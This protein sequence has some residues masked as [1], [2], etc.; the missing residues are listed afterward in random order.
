M[1]VE[2]MRTSMNRFRC[3]AFVTVMVLA[4]TSSAQSLSSAYFLSG[5]YTRQDLNPAFSPERA[6]FSLPV[7]GG[8]GMSVSSNVGASAFIYNSTSYP[9]KLT[10][11]MSGD[12][13]KAT[14]LNALPDVSKLRSSVAIDVASAGFRAFGGYG[15]VGLS[16]KSY[17]DVSVPK[18]LFAMMKSGLS[19]GHYMAG[20]A[21][22]KSL[23]YADLGLGYSRNVLDNLKLGAKVHFLLGMAGGDVSINR[24]DAN[25][26]SSEWRLMMDAKAHIGMSGLEIAGNDDGTANLDSISY[27]YKGLSGFGLALDFGAVYDLSDVVEGLSVSAAITDLG[28]L[29]WNKGVTLANDGKNEVVFKGFHDVS[30]DEDLDKQAD[31]LGEDVKSM[32]NLTEKNFE[33]YNGGPSATFRLGVQYR[34]PWVDWISAGELLTFRTGLLSCLE[35]RTSVNIAPARWFDASLNVAFST[36]GTD[37]GWVLDFHPKAVSLFIGSDGVRARLSKDGIPV[38]ASSASVMF[39]LKFALGDIID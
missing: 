20:N 31:Q 4:G 35:S 13:S 17:E 37:L 26:N 15:N 27:R 9:G 29:N 7:I 8:T 18:S 11:F 21:R 39:G 19:D 34:L 30:G 16:L 6:Y 5:S 25:I 1:I 2:S 23:A 24:I 3:V 10:T 33:S 14:F 12:V 32:I 22:V 36:F 28:Y 38:S